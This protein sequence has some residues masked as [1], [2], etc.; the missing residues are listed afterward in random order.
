MNHM[1]KEH[2]ECNICR[3]EKKRL[4]FYKDVYNIHLHNKFQHFQCPNPDCVNDL[5]IVFETKQKAIE[6]MTIKHNVSA[7][8]AV[9]KI[10][11]YKNNNIDP[12]NPNKIIRN[13]RENCFDVEEHVNLLKEKT[14]NY[15]AQLKEEPKKEEQKRIDDN[16]KFNNNNYKSFKKNQFKKNINSIDDYFKHNNQS[17]YKVV[18]KELNN[19]ETT[20]IGKADKY[21]N[22]NETGPWN[23][24]LKSM[25]KKTSS[26]PK[27]PEKPVLKIDDY[28]SYFSQ[29]YKEVKDFITNKLK[30][31][32]TDEDLVEISADYGYQL[33]IIIDKQSAKENSELNMITNFGFNISLV[34]E[35]LNCFANNPGYRL[36]DT[37]QKIQLGKL[38]ILYKFLHICYMK[39]SGSYYKKGNNNFL[40]F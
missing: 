5:F 23:K 20:E 17:N 24:N 11:S 15:I 33:I 37:L 9:E 8:K 34:D 36:K 38:L 35:I 10:I 26:N 18:V 29:Y 3:K 1:T 21:G 13:Y 14:K 32:N 25:E 28:A 31:E 19:G 16:E 22:E 27:K 30:S 4:V 7:D 12:F 2:F 6:H 39:E 40:N